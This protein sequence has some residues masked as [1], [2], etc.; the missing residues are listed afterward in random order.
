[1]NGAAARSRL[2][3]ILPVL[4]VLAVAVLVGRRWLVNR[5]AAD[6]PLV[7]SGTVE[8]TESHLGFPAS[9]LLARV[10]VREGE[11]V[12]A[13]QPLAWLDDREARARRAQAVAQAAAARA[14]L[15]ELERGF[16]SEE[17]AEARAAL[18]AADRQLDDARL[19]FGRTEKLL[20]GGAVSQ[21]DFDK[22]SVAR[23]VAQSR[24]AQAAERLALLQRGPR[25]EQIAAQRAVVAQAAA[26]VAALDAT[27]AQMAVLAPFA[28][29]VTVRHRE[30]GEIVPPGAPVL[31]VL[32]PAD[33][34]VRIY[35][36]EP[37]L[38]RVALGAPATITSDTYKD[39][40]YA[41]RVRFIASEAEFTPKTV[42][43]TE[44]RVKLVY[45]VKV[46]IT[47]DSAFELKPG[48]PADVRLEAAAHAGR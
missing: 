7:A 16:R 8:A 17:V 47:G 29:V 5:A 48:M 41:G 38:G 11:R 32:D 19:V 31:T 22:A 36:P 46:Y 18:E 30:P 13:G 10:A 9:G 27:L 6:G 21:E 4:A 12:T 23:D 2:K 40:E 39:R 3:R 14:R 42:Q 20:A 37:R 1:M 34:W 26:S 24:R 43:T 28:G 33:R 45:A 44:E 15:S 25:R 35:V